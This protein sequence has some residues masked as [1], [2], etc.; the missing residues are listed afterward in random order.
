M[1][2]AENKS[3]VIVIPIAGDEGFM[4]GFIPINPLCP[5]KEGLKGLCPTFLL[6]V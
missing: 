4:G 6:S 5:A 2:D 3:V 1:K